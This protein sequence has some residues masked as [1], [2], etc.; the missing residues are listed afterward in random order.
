MRPRSPLLNP[1]FAVLSLALAAFVVRTVLKVDLGGLN[2]FVEE[3]V[4]S[5]IELGAAALII[6]RAATERRGRLAWSLLAVYV[7]LWTIGDLGWTLHYDH[8]DEAPFPNWTD[9]VYLSS[10]AFGYA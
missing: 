5:G 9:A 2:G 6:W 4:Y 10:Y 3:W 7:L 1:I 8:M